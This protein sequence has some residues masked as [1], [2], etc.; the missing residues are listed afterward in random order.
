MH[1]G[2]LAAFET[3]ADIENCWQP[4]HV[5]PAHPQVGP[6]KPP[7]PVPEGVEEESSP[8]KDVFK[9]ST[10]GPATGPPS[11]VSTS[12]DIISVTRERNALR[13]QLQRVRAFRSLSRIAFDGHQT[14]SKLLSTQVPFVS[15]WSWVTSPSAL[16]QVEREKA[17]AKKRVEVLQLQGEN[18]SAQVAPSKAGF[19]IISVLLVAILAFLLGE[20]LPTI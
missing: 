13:D 17:D 14:C 16:E 3:A 18:R 10:S 20:W 7:S 6:P 4:V 19:G 15:Q 2:W 12:E 9:D 5:D 8:S 1:H 11:T